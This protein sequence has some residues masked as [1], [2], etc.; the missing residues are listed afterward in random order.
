[1]RYHLE[2][3]MKTQ[4]LL[5]TS[6]ICIITAGNPLSAGADAAAPSD[7]TSLVSR[8]VAEHHLDR[9]G[10]RIEERFN[11]DRSIFQRARPGSLENRSVPIK[12]VPL[13]LPIKSH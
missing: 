1:M 10:D 9:K 5:S 7:P 12:S 8:D 4:Q 11:G 2:A 6:I 13:N 3:T